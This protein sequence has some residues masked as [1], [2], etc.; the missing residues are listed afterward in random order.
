MKVGEA[1]ALARE[2]NEIVER[3]RVL[4]E[5]AKVLCD[6]CNDIREALDA[7]GVQY[8]EIALLFGG[9]LDIEVVGP[10]DAEVKP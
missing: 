2:F 5:Q 9:E 1:R 8:D 7:E 3:G 6:R 4:W 10:D